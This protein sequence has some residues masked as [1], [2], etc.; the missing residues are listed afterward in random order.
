MAYESMSDIK[1]KLKWAD[2]HISDFKTA[3]AQYWSTKPYGVRVD[4]ETDPAKPLIH[5]IKADPVPPEIRLI[6]GDVIQHLRSTLDYLACA[7]VRAN[8]QPVGR[9]IEFPISDGPITSKNEDRFAAK[10]KGMR[11]EV[12]RQIK[13]VHA[14]QGG[15]NLLWRLHRLNIVD[16]HNMLVTALG[17]ITAA[18]D[19]PPIG[20]QWNGNRWMGIPGVPL[21]LKA[22]DKFTIESPTMKV[23]RNTQFFAEIVFDQPDIAEGYP[24]VL[25]FTQIR[26]RVSRVLGEFSCWLK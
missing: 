25:A 17:G 1:E 24:V 23:D 3:V 15:D 12:I 19:L 8:N 2:K 11:K 18:N 22:G 5:I 26:N 4:D 7:L 13:D 21:T 14:Y 20:D 10:V 9:T 16:K 6:A